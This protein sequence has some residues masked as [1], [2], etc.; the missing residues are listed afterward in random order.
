MK[1]QVK[2]KLSEAQLATTM[3]KIT[4]SPTGSPDADL[5]KAI[6]DVKKNAKQIFELAKTKIASYQKEL[7]K[8]AITL[9]EGVDKKGLIGQ[10]INAVVVRPIVRFLKS[11]VTLNPDQVAEQLSENSIFN[12][13]DLLDNANIIPEGSP[14]LQTISNFYDWVQVYNDIKPFLL[15]KETDPYS[16]IEAATDLSFALKE[17]TIAGQIPSL[18]VL[19]TSLMSAYIFSKAGAPIA[20]YLGNPKGGLKLFGFEPE[21]DKTK[22][23]KYFE[24]YQNEVHQEIN[25][26]IIEGNTKVIEILNIIG[27]KFPWIKSFSSKTEPTANEMYLME[28]TKDVIFDKL[29][30]YN[31]ILRTFKTFKNGQRW[32]IIKAQL[33]WDSL[34]QQDKEFVNSLIENFKKTN[35]R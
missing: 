32:P 14:Y 16:Y 10:G 3:R 6:N 28:N 31:T 5:Q 12:I 7:D 20:R 1:L 2:M 33:N 19:N 25:K 26:A 17:S 30:I 27:N 22:I 29:K 8:I 9:E 34:S 21:R 18:D 13:Y 35:L 24:D 11:L 15:K 23:T 4:D